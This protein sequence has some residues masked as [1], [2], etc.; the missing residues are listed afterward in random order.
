MDKMRA[1]NPEDLEKVIGGAT[2]T[3]AVGNKSYA[4]FCNAWNALGLSAVYPGNSEM[5]KQYNS[6]V[7]SGSPDSAYDFL[8]PLTK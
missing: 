2:E 1:L 6:W 4:E 7:N 3:P 8:L 5:E